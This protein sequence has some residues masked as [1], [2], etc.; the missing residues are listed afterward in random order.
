MVGNGPISFLDNTGMDYPGRFSFY[1]EDNVVIDTTYTSNFLVV[2]SVKPLREF[3]FR[4]NSFEN[5]EMVS[6]SPLL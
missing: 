2:N 5:F 6:S 1:F 3:V 4:N